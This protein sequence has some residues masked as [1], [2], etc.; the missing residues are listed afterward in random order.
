M[1]ENNVNPKLDR[2][3]QLVKKGT[4][5]SKL[6]SSLSYEGDKQGFSPLQLCVSA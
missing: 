6:I 4:I 1:M 3:M 2:Q 5:L